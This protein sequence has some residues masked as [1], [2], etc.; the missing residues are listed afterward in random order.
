MRFRWRK[1]TEEVPPLEVLD[2]GE[3]EPPAFEE[4]CQ[5]VRDDRLCGRPADRFCL[6]CSLQVCEADRRHHRLLYVRQGAILVL[7]CDGT[8]LH[9]GT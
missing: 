5:A 1:R 6:R 4:R 8:E 7:H 2:D 9:P 3:P